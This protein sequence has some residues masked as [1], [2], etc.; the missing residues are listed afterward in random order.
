MSERMNFNDAWVF[1][2]DTRP[3]LRHNFAKGESVSL[4]H[5][6]CELP[7]NYT[8]ETVYQKPF[9]YQKS[10]DFD[11]DWEGQEVALVLD[12]A[13]ADAKI[14]LNGKEI[15]AHKDGYTPIHARLT[16]G[17]LPGSNLL[18]VE[19]DGTENPLIPP[20]GG[21][22]D[23]LT[24]AGIYRDVWL[25]VAAP[26]SIGSVKIETPDVLKDKKTVV[27][28]LDLEN[29]QALAFEGQLSAHILNSAGKAVAETSVSVSAASKTIRFE[30]IGSIA[31]WT[32]KAP[33][34]YTLKLTLETEHGVNETETQFG[35]R[36]IE[37]TTKGFFL[38]GEP[39]KLRGL[40]RH[41]SF[42]YV[43]YA[44][45]RSA[46]ERDAVIVKHDLG[47]NVVRSSHYPP[48]PYF[49]DHCDRIGLLVLEE[50]PGWQHLGGDKWKAESVRNVERMIR[51]DWN[52]P[53][54]IMWGV[55]INESP[56]EH[57]FYTRTNER[58]RSL[59]TTR[60][61]GGIRCITDSEF[62]E[63]VYTMNDFVL[64]MDE[65]EADRERTPLRPQ[66]EVT[67]LDH[68]VPYLV[69]EYNGHMFPTKSFDHE[70]R[71]DEHVRRHL[72][73]M[74]AAY[75][76]E[77][78][79]GCIGWCAFDYN[80][81]S[82]FG[83]GDGICYHGVVDM[84]REPKFAAFAYA[85]QVDPSERVV[86]EPVTHYARG[87][88]NIGG[89]FPLTILTNCDEIEVSFGDTAPRRIKPDTKT[90]PHLPHPPVIVDTA[91]FSDEEMG[92]WGQKWQTTQL[93]GFVNGEKVMD[94]TLAAA[95]IPT[96]LQVVP[97]TTN[98]DSKND[99]VRVMVRALD[100]TGRKLP[101]FFETVE[102]EVTGAGQL[103]GP[104]VIPMRGGATGFWVTSNGTSGPIGV[105]ATTAALGTQTV[106]LQVKELAQ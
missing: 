28:E 51:R 8:D 59:D 76:D 81:H 44:L 40:N 7:F 12:G 42:P 96:T 11:P 32:L 60:P 62:L 10:F 103:I 102:I 27:V 85:S 9:T 65:I 16:D 57:D 39:L 75:G 89:V 29:P 77:T 69:T 30:N 73:V 48:S 64:G 82:D 5:N 78:S 49:L 17:L 93:S 72:E 18:T 105:R 61:T 86:L 91:H 63:D 55:R 106:E 4:P 98:L 36:H 66:Q 97:D 79:S 22:I 13:M 90:Y 50:I 33:H 58:A 3:D 23:Y 100:Q 54:I 43:G 21:Q 80:T 104:S 20:F 74:N 38:N 53:S 15:A 24:Y 37:F 46:Q 6:A 25:D 41:Q 88:R 1:H 101:Y 70:V 71:Q 19:I 52:H 31:L 56:D 84:F 92:E 2:T 83:S 26:V 95:K 99:C 14:F 34:L 67:G 45:P 87:E 35:F 94:V 47:C 68:D